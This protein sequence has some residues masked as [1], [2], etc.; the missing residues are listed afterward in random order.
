MNI[1]EFEN[2]KTYLNKLLAPTGE[3]RGARSKL[4]EKLNCNIGFISQ[5][6]NGGSQFSLEHTAQIAEFLDLSEK[7]ADFFFLLVQFERA[8]SEKLKKHLKR[9]IS[10]IQKQRKEI[11][12]RIKD[13]KELTEADYSTYYSNWSYVAIHMALSITQYQSKSAL[14]EKLGLTSKQV[15]SVIQ[16]LVQKGLIIEEK[17][18][19]KTGP[20]RIHL[21]R[22]SPLICQHHSNWR[23][24]SMKAIPKQIE[25]N[26]H[27]SSVMT[28]SVADAEKIRSVVLKS[29]EDVEVILRP[30]PNEEV[31]VLGIDFFKL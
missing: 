31:F 20:T 21:S 25:S 4:A 16:F 10:A 30:S 12:S 28:M 19:Y 2:Y 26:L 8:G 29:L 18:N 27:Y 5:V 3:T 6:L 13:S 24:E 11:K 9:Q 7:E 1:F 14:K 22:S 15:D 23:I 17:G